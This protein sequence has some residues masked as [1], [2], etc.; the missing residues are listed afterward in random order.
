MIRDL[1]FE[2]LGKR[3]ISR[4]N[5]NAEEI[6]YNNFVN[7]RV[8]LTFDEVYNNILESAPPTSYLSWVRY[9]NNDETRKFKDK[10]RYRYNKFKSVREICLYLHSNNYLA[11]KFGSP[12]EQQVQEMLNKFDIWYK[13][14]EYTKDELRELMAFVGI[15]NEDEDE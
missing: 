15:S 8:S 13:Y 11:S 9:N 5:E 10:L 7:N 1:I 6:L 14:R 3:N 2:I 12:N 4:W